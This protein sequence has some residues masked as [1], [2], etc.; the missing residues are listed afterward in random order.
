MRK[1]VIGLIFVLALISMS[2]VSASTNVYVE[3]ASTVVK[4][5]QDFNVSI[6]INTTESIY[7]IE[8]N[9]I[10]NPSILNATIV[11]EG[12]FL[13]QDNASTYPIISINNSIGKIIFADTRLGTQEGVFG[14]GVLALIK[15]KAINTGTSDLDLD[16]VNL[17]DAN[18]NTIPVT[19]DDGSVEVREVACYNNSDCGTNGWVGNTTCSNE[20]VWQP[21]EINVCTNPGTINA[22]CVVTSILKLKQDCGVDSCGSFGTNYCKDNDVYHNQTCHDKGC[23]NG[24]CFDNIFVNE[25][26]FQEC[27]IA[28]CEAGHCKG[29]LWLILPED[30]AEL[31]RTEP[32][33]FDWGANPS[34]IFKKCNIQVSNTLSTRKWGKIGKD[35]KYG[36][37]YQASEKDWSKL[38]KLAEKY[39]KKYNTDTLY[40]RVYC[41]GKK[42]KEYSNIFSFSFV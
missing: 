13:K 11:V 28:G 12:N 8:F 19:V 41:Q 10:F 26:K 23:S 38:I 20:D 2:L 37:S 31:S 25:T 17:V 1:K 22:Y 5:G 35:I 16:N 40:W 24:A 33:F 21:W 3:P 27:G 39:K 9:L 15:F 4:L 32:E 42:L 7:A 34:L 29:N 6:D 30:G 36:T 14:T 18:L